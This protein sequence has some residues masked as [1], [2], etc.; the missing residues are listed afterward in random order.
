MEAKVGQPLAL[1]LQEALLALTG[2]LVDSSGLRLFSLDTPVE[3]LWA[4]SG[5]W[6][7]LP[8]QTL[9]SSSF[10]SSTAP[11]SSLKLHLCEKCPLVNI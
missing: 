8:L 6:E 1:L 9:P 11:P 3:L 5:M 7:P 4:G 2:P 10:P